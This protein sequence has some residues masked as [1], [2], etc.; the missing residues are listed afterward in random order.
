MDQTY[1][2]VALWRDAGER[3][4]AAAAVAA[5]S[6]G[7]TL[8][9][10]ITEQFTFHGRDQVRDLLEVALAAIDGISY[11]DQVAQDRTVA[12]FYEA[13]VGGTR[14]FEAQRLR[15]GQ[16]GLITEITLYIRPLPALTRLL[17]RLGPE[18]ARRNGRPGLARVIP[19]AGGLLHAMADSGERRIMPKAAPQSKS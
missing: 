13:T 6:P 11:T 4:D 7:V 15:L 9:S 8:V 3:G 2:A 16:D 5:L 12:L 10:P 1:D 18:L 19:L 17:N 14:L